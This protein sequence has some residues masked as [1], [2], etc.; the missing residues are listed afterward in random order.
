MTNHLW[1]IAYAI[2]MILI[3]FWMRGVV[4]RIFKRHYKIKEK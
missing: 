4:E 3:Y 1:L 2:L